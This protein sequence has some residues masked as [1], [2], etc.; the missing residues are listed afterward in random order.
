[1]TPISKRKKKKERVDFIKSDPDY[2]P[3]IVM[4]EFLQ[5]WVGLANGGRNLTFS[6]NP[7]EA[8]VLYFDTQFKYLRRATIFKLEQIYI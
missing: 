5:V 4:N 8:K 2:K 1:M 3:Y 7:E 6:D